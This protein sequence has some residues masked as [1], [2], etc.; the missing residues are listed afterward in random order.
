M[1]KK[2]NAIIA[3]LLSSILI[4]AYDN[5]AAAFAAQPIEPPKPVVVVKP[6]EPVKPPVVIKPVEPVKPPIIKPIEPVKPIE[7]PAVIK[8]EVVEDEDV[9]SP[10]S[11]QESEGGPLRQYD[12]EYAVQ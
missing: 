11:L 9:D 4:S 10:S 6:V 8:Q 2:S 7:L 1:K 3:L 5:P 12:T